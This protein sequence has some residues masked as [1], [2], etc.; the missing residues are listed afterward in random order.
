MSDIRKKMAFEDG[1]RMEVLRILN[2]TWDDGILKTANGREISY[3]NYKFV[4]LFD[5]VVKLNNNRI[6]SGVY[7]WG[8][9]C[10]ELYESDSVDVTDCEAVNCSLFSVDVLKQVLTILEN[11]GN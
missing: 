5:R 4:D 1:I 9:L 11:Y 6:V 3:D 7:L 8:N 2:L 10:V